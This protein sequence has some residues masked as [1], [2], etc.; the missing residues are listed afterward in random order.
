MMPERGFS[1]K[2]N[3]K[4]CGLVQPGNTPWRRGRGGDGGGG[5]CFVGGAG[6]G[7]GS[8]SWTSYCSW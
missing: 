7:S 6:D 8:R 4:P 2:M 1:K 5:G 3:P